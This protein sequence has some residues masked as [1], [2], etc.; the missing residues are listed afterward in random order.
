MGQCLIYEAVVADDTGKSDRFRNEC[1]RV[2][3][4]RGVFNTHNVAARGNVDR[5]IPGEKNDDAPDK[6][7]AFIQLLKQQVS[8]FLPKLPRITCVGQDH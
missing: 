6:V 7:K 8:H 4:F 3:E 1:G 2:S 5:Q